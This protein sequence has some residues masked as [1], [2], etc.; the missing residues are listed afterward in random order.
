VKA[1]IAYIEGLIRYLETRQT[2]ATITADLHRT[3]EALEVHA[4]DQIKTM[5]AKTEAARSC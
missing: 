1:I 3:V 5:K 4:A 2:V